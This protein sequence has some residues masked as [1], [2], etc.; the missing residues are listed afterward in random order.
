MK[1]YFAHVYSH[2]SYGILF[3]GNHPSA[4]RIFILQKRAVRLICGVSSKY[5][6]KPLLADL[7]I[8]TLPS[9]Y[10]MFCIASCS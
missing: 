5:H 10:S 6:C 4:S 1:I 2:I 8:L 9:L 3:W 7:G